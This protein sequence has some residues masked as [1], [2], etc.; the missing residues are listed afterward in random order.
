MEITP[1]GKIEERERKRDV[2]NIS[3]FVSSK[4]LDDRSPNC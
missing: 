2:G 1:Q 3:G 4:K